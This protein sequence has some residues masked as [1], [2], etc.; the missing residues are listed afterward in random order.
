MTAVPQKLEVAPR[1]MTWLSTGGN[2]TGYGFGAI[3]L[4]P[5]TLQW[6]EHNSWSVPIYQRAVL[7]P[8]APTGK[9]STNATVNIGNNSWDIQLYYA[10]TLFP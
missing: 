7:D 5:V 10:V 9:S 3:T 4:G 8:D 6:P 2:R 1:Q